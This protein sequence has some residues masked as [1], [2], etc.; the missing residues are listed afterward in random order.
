MKSDIEKILSSFERD[1]SASGVASIESAVAI[2]AEFSADERMELLRELV[3]LD[4]EYRR[5][6]ERAKTSLDSSAGTLRAIPLVED[7][8]ARFPELAQS[9]GDVI[10]LIA[11]E[12]RT[13]RRCG[14]RELAS[15]YQK[16]FPGCGG[17]IAEIFARVDSMIE[18]ERLD[19]TRGRDLDDKP[20]NGCFAIRANIQVNS[21]SEQ[22]TV[23]PLIPGYAIVGVLG[24]G[25]MGIVY[26]ARRIGLDREVAVG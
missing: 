17:E 9:Q 23:L 10:E 6:G 12:Y 24:R 16:R 4:M 3:I 19:S 11:E 15:S 2:A 13:R 25:A 8:P 20:A 21:E 22:D 7:N 1:W 5:G 26:K 14:E 18:S